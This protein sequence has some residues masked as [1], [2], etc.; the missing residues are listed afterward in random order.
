VFDMKSGIVLAL[1]LCQAFRD[2]KTDPGKDVVFFFSSDEEIGTEKG[3]PHLRA[4]AEPCRAVLCLEPSLPGG[5]AKTSR[6]GVGGFTVRVE[7]TA[8]HAGVDHEKG[9]NAILE[10]SRLIVRLQQMTDYGRGVTL[11]VG[12][13]RGGTAS[14]VVPA[15]ATAEVDFRVATLAD[16]AELETAVRALEPEDPRCRIEIVGG[17]NRP[18]LERTPEVVALYQRARAVGRLLGM[19]LGEGATGGGSDGSFTAA[20]GIPTLD[21][22]GVEGDGAHAVHEAIV[23]DDIPR[24]AAMLAELIRQL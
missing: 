4:A 21:G 9:V 3:L 22:L 20:M 6:K 23:V 2:G 18:P 24:R 10:L 5:K 12:R 15:E 1:M 17:L 16:A 11:N 13:V 14:N 7:G 8:A 19:E